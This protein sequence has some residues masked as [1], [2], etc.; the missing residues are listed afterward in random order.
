[1]AVWEKAIDMQTMRRSHK[2]NVGNW[3]RWIL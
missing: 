2:D 3:F 1:M